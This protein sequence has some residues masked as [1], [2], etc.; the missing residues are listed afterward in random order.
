[1]VH[2]EQDVV[3]VDQGHLLEVTTGVGAVVSDQIDVELWSTHHL[4]AIVKFGHLFVDLLCE[5][6]LWDASDELSEGQ[7]DILDSVLVINILS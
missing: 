6:I 7:E 1:M 4:A 3:K 5:L 2:V